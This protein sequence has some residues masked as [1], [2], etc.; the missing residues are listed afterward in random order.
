MGGKMKI[1]LIAFGVF[2]LFGSAW[3]FLFGGPEVQIQ[4]AAYPPLM[5]N[6]K[7]SN[8]NELVGVD[9]YSDTNR[10]YL[11]SIS[12]RHSVPKQITYGD[13]PAGGRQILPKRGKPRQIKVSEKILVELRYQYDT[14]LD[15]W[16]GSQ[17]W[18]LRLED[19]QKVILLGRL[20]GISLPPRPQMQE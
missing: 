4:S 12:I 7:T 11:W 1:V 9:F 19:A 13:L 5:L 18:G 14:W 10:E 6:L 8:I 17:V 16:V 20:P 2:V 3:Y 15:P